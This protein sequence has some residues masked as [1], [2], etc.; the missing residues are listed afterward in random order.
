M[1]GTMDGLQTFDAEA[2]NALLRRELAAV[3]VYT[4]ALAI[5]GNE[6]VIAELQRIRAEHRR[7]VCHLRDGLVAGG[8]PPADGGGV[9]G[10]FGSESAGAKALGPATVLAML[11]QGE[12]SGI[13]EYE[14]ALE[15]AELHPDCLRAIQAELLPACRRHV[16]E[17]NRLL[18]GAGC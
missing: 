1:N 4:Q 7:A 6:A 11:R 8:A 3:A 15:G 17:L 14:A 16:E 13:T 12:E 10:A 5:F 18:G 9:W 2:V